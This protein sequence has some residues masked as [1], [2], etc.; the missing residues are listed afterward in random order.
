MEGDLYI[1]YTFKLAPSAGS[2]EL[3]IGL[4]FD[5]HQ[6]TQ[7]WLLAADNG[8]ESVD[9]CSSLLRGLADQNCRRFAHRQQTVNGWTTRLPLSSFLTLPFNSLPGICDLV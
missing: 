2:T 8:D 7:L 5:R 1:S 9:V 3:C 4:T 6:A